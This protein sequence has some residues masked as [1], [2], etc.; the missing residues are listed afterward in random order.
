MLPG[1]YDV[2]AGGTS[3]AQRFIIS[4][5]RR[6]VEHFTMAS[7]VKSTTLR[8]VCSAASKRSFST[9]LT[10]SF[11]AVNK[12]STTA[13]SQRAI[14]SAFAKDALSGSMRVA[15]FHASRRQAILPPLPRKLK[16]L[17][18]LRHLTN[19]CYS[20]VIQGTSMFTFYQ[21]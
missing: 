21:P 5:P 1:I 13:L 7:I 3:N 2:D 8:Q 12:T 6:R 10:P 20:E 4:T 9:K 19:V 18:L 11:P 15:A 14:K 16:L 17:V